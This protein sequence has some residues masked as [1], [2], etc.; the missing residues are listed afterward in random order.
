MGA[1]Y[2]ANKYKLY[3][4]T[5]MVVD[6]H[7]NGLPVCFTLASSETTDT[8]LQWLRSYVSFQ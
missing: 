1:T 7:V 4:V 3:L 8:Y 2:S 5:L 6:E